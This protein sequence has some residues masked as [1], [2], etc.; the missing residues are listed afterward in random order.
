MKEVVTKVTDMLTQEDSHGALKNL[1]ERYNRCI[2]SEF[3][4]CP[5]NKSAHTKKA[6]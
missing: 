5:I 4:V 6:W 1:L 2:V 3:H